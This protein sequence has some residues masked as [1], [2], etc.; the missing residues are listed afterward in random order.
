LSPPS[1]TPPSN[2]VSATTSPHLFT[3]KVPPLYHHCIQSC[4]LHPFTTVSLTTTEVSPQ[5][6]DDDVSHCQPP[7]KHHVH[8]VAIASVKD[9]VEAAIKAIQAHFNTTINQTG[10][11]NKKY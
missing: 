11:N 2:G 3:T 9:L 4:L 6:L 5:L 10:L 8:F 1:K 7:S